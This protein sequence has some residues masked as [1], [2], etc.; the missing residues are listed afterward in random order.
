[1]GILKVRKDFF[2]NTLAIVYLTFAVIAVGIAIIIF[3]GNKPSN[4]G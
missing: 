1:V 4:K 3:V 2:M